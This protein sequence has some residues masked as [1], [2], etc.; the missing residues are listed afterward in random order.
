MLVKLLHDAAIDLSRET[1]RYVN[2]MWP[3]LLTVSRGRGEQRKQE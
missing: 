3:L 2:I 1:Q